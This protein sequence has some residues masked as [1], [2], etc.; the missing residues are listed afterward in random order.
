MWKKSGGGSADKTRLGARYDHNLSPQLF[1]FGQ[2][3]FEQDRMANLDLRGGL[4]AGFGY[5]LMKE[6][7]VTLDVFGGLSH[8]RSD[9]MTGNT[10]SIVKVIM[11]EESTHAL[12]PNTR[13]KQKLS[14]YLST[15]T[16]GE[17]RTVFDSSLVISL[18]STMSLS[19]SL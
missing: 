9:M 1:G 6:D 8:N 4:G 15:Q 5:H 19:I 17:F 10:V 3:G 16:G 7:S 11:A 12:T 14:Y 2:L 13:F 18:N